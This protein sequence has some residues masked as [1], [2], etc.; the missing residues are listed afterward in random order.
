[1]AAPHVAGLAALVMSQGVTDPK[2]VEKILRATARD[3]GADGKDNEFGYGL[4]QARA[5]IYGVGVRK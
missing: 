4:I 2:A 1:M 5:A 3:L